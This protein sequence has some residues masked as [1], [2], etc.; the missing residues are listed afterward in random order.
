MSTHVP[1][2]IRADT[3]CLA[4]TRE[5]ASPSYDIVRYCSKNQ[6]GGILTFDTVVAVHVR[7]Q[8]A[9]SI[10]DSVI[11]HARRELDTPW[12]D[13]AALVTPVHPRRPRRTLRRRRGQR[14]KGRA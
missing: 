8:T 1:F 13:V 14:R 7:A 6:N 11:V 10:L 2:C 5:R 9:G 12:K 3:K 4:A